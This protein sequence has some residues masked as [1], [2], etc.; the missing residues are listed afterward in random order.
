[1]LQVIHVCF[2]AVSISNLFLYEN[3]PMLYTAIFHGC[4][5]D[6]FQIKKCDNFLIFA[7]NI[8]RGY[9]LEPPHRSWVHVRTAS[10]LTSTHDL[11]F[12]S[13]ISSYDANA[14]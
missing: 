10:V 7:Q 5:K 12:R 14:C 1:M 8:D 3:T 11:C 4:K 6:H 2:S 13:K 9:S